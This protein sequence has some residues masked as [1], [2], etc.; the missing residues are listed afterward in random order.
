MPYILYICCAYY[1]HLGI[2]VPAAI[3]LGELSIT[4]V[5]LVFLP[6]SEVAHGIRVET[7]PQ[8]IISGSDHYHMYEIMYV[9][10]LLH[11]GSVQHRSGQLNA[12]TSAT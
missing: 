9:T 10:S 4:G 5:V 12:S 3:L 2:T 1:P 11:Q 8:R 7:D 6:L